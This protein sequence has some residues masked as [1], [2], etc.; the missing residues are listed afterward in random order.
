MTGNS[1]AYPRKRGDIAHW[2]EQTLDDE[3][4]AESVRGCTDWQELLK[5]I[6]ERSELLWSHL[7]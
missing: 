7:T 3:K 1:I 4:L 2:I 5:V 6:N